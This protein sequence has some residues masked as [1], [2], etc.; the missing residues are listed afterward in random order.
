MLLNEVGELAREGDI[1][2]QNILFGYLNSESEEDKFIAY[3]HLADFPQ[4]SPEI[5]EHLE[6]FINNEENSQ[7]ILEVQEVFGIDPQNVLVPSL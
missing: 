4:K 2:A 6:K 7:I 3:A 1:E 5:L